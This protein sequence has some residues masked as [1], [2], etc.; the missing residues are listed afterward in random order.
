V[1]K[2]CHV[3]F[4]WPLNATSFSFP[5]SKDITLRIASLLFIFTMVPLFRQTARQIYL[6]HSYF[7]S[8]RSG[9]A[10]GHHGRSLF[11]K[12]RHVLYRLRK[13]RQHRPAHPPKHFC[14]DWQLRQVL[15]LRQKPTE[16]AGDQLPGML[17]YNFYQWY[18][19]DA[20]KQLQ[21]WPNH[22]PGQSNGQHCHLHICWQDVAA[23]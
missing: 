11:A 5:L 2:R 6:I 18:R 12:H 23:G 15:R 22:C 8:C 9:R 3:L 13:Y 14:S 7:S 21:P 17:F 20:S 1:R 19:V 16:L 4:E 10:I